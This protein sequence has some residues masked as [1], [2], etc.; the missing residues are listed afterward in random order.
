MKK[1]KVLIVGGHISPAISLIEELQKSEEYS[2]GFIGRMHPLEG[3]ASFS[4]EYKTI[5][6]LDIPFHSITTGR[7]ERHFG[8]SFLTSLIKIPLGFIQSVYYLCKIRPEVVVAFGGYVSFPIGITCYLLNIPVLI[9]EQT[10]SLGLSN[11][12]LSHFANITFLTFNQTKY[13][14][15]GVKT[16]VTGMLK[17]TYDEKKA[18]KEI[19]NFGNKKL[20]LIFISG[21][22]LGSRSVNYL[23]KETLP[24]LLLKYRVLHQCGEARE[25]EDYKN[26]LLEKQRLDQNISGNYHVFTNCDYHTF[27][28]ILKSSNLVIGRSGANTV[29]D[30][31]NLS[32]KSV[33]IPLPWSGDNEQLINAQRFVK[34]HVGVILEQKNA[35]PD[36]LLNAI[37]TVLKIPVLKSDKE[38]KSEE[39]ASASLRMAHVIHSLQ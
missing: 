27:Y 18:K 38:N 11:R 9:H 34:E 13:V 22:S 15:R 20:P 1:K 36:S 8:L 3:D 4:L 29:S 39:L 10:E 2:L 31:S 17:R 5:K 19:I 21:G 28:F 16:E 12:I 14:P 30:L 37:E 33:F 7:I 6:E 24:D 35:N 26:L 32:K 23:I 25:S